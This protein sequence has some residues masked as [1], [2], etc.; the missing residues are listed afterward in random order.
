MDC[1]DLKLEAVIGFTG[2]VCNGLHYTPCGQYI[3][4]PLAAGVVVRS[5]TTG[6]LAFLDAQT[7]GDVTC[8]AVSR[9]GKYLASGHET[10]GSAKAYA[11]VWD[12]EKAKQNCQKEK[13]SA[14]GCLIH[15]LQQHQGEVRALDFNSDSTLLATL[16]GRDDND[17]V[18]WDVESGK[19]IC[20]SPAANESS[21]CIKWLNGRRD[22]FVS[23]GNNHLRVWQVCTLTPK[24]HPIDANM[25]S[26]RRNMQCLDISN[27]DV[28]TFVGSTTGEVLK[29]A[30]TRDEIQPFAKPDALQPALKDYNQNRF[31]KGVL[32]VSCIINP[33][34]GNTNVIAGSGDGVVQILNP[35]LQ[36]I[37]SHKAELKGGV[38]SL[39]LSP[40]NKTFLAGTEISQRYSVDVSSFTPELRST[41]HHGS[42]N[43]VRFPANCSEIF[44]T[45]SVK[46]IRVW[47]ARQRNELLRI[48][49]PNRTSN[50][51]DI[52]PS[53]TTIV[54][55][56]SDG[57][58]RAFFPE[59]GKLM[60][61]IPDAHTGEVTALTVCASDN[62]LGHGWRMISG[63]EDGRV[64]VWKVTKTH[65]IML[66]STKEHRG[67]INSV[68]CNSD[69]SQVLSS[70]SDGSCIVWDL[71]KGTR[72]HAL[73]DQTIFHGGLYHPDESQYLTCGSNYKLG[74]WD[75][76]NATAIRMVEGGEA[77]IT[78]VDIQPSNG[79]WFVS[80]GADRSVKVWHYDDGITT[81]V[82]WG[83][84]GKVHSVRI[85]PDEK[86]I[87]SVGQDGAI[88]IWSGLPNG[89]EKAK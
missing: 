45:A 83:H 13:P 22:R 63:G 75:A 58:I 79:E 47:N 80:G 70:A 34:T 3:V 57:I 21:R 87:V 48:Q 11:Y 16:G 43:D 84:S 86:K 29:F 12:L 59:S 15:S 1:K 33:L 72:I 8:L 62:D 76:S 74:Y 82:G 30:I 54:S 7:D 14:G 6:N 46:D 89:C 36:P 27:D 35:K 44:V 85:S 77:E 23:C 64:K 5:I 61:S 24:L 56:W 41:C 51:I 28:F 55:G 39:S 18:V 42:V 19:G 78:C 81:G 71:D 37:V 49:V 40:D 32:S 53:G 25:G 68:V 66:H 10:F 17:V 60:F 38:T 73:L 20:G 67:Q 9:N 2:C 88:F 52:T 4:Y 31:S 50:A 69:G 65:Q 26:I